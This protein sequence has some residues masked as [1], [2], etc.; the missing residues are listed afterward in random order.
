M[1]AATPS[2]MLMR[3]R[4][5]R[6]QEYLSGQ[7]DFTVDD[8]MIME[9]WAADIANAQKGESLFQTEPPPM[10]LSDPVPFV[11]E[12]TNKTQSSRGSKR[13]SFNRNSFNFRNRN[14]A[15]KAVP[16]IF[17]PSPPP[18]DNPPAPP[19]PHPPDDSNVPQPP[20]SPHAPPSPH[21]P[22]PPQDTPSPRPPP[23]PRRP[24]SV[25]CEHHLVTNNPQYFIE[26]SKKFDPS[27][28]LVPSPHDALISPSPTF[29]SNSTRLTSATSTPASAKPSMPQTRSQPWIIAPIPRQLS[30]DIQASRPQSHHNSKPRAQSQ[31]TSHLSHPHP[32]ERKMNVHELSRRMTFTQRVKNIFWRD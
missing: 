25:D 6:L 31:P 28:L 20:L 10:D 12:P 15:A 19:S 4:M 2:E 11:P 21:H 26:G 18:D 29:A 22:Q 16:P 3:V 14:S 27:C 5:Q 24:D 23:S 30:K 1:A 32:M 17:V 13:L 7:G 9:A 8:I